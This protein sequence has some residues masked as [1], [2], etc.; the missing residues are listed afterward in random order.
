MQERQFPLL[1]KPPVTLIY[2]SFNSLVGFFASQDIIHD[3]RK[4]RNVS[5]GSFLNWY[6]FLGMRING[7]EL[8]ISWVLSFFQVHV[9]QLNILGIL[10][11]IES[12]LK[13]SIFFHFKTRFMKCFAIRKPFS[14]L[15]VCKF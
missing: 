14:S 9:C 7:K 10:L 4:L 5:F 11:K 13:S 2:F 6:F 8:L 15:F 1:K 12:F 3:K